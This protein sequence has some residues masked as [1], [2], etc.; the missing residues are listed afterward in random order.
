EAKNRIKDELHRLDKPVTINTKPSGTKLEISGGPEVNLGVLPADKGK[1]LEALS[2]NNKLL[3]KELALITDKDGKRALRIGDVVP[4]G[5]VR[6]VPW[7]R[8]GFLAW[9]FSDEVPVLLEPLVKFLR[10]I[11]YLLDPAAGGWNRVFLILVILW[12]LATWALF[13]G[14][15]TRMAAVQ[16]AR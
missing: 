15:I 3:L 14:A 8:G 13:G 4:D 1:R 9:F 6:S 11:V 16:V 7:E 10:P 2:A 12:T 5:T